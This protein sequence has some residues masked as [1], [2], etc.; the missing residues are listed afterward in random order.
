MSNTSQRPASPSL[1]CQVAIRFNTRPG[2]FDIADQVLAEQ[3]LT[4][5]LP[6]SAD[7]RELFLVS[8]GP[9]SAPPF[10]RPLSHVLVERFC[11]RRT[12]NLTPHEHYVTPVQEHDPDKAL[13]LDLYP[14]VLMINECGPFMLEA[15]QQALIAF[16][17]DTDDKGQTPWQWYSDYLQQQFT[18]AVQDSQRDATLSADALSATQWVQSH[19]APTSQADLDSPTIQVNNLRL[20]FVSNWQLDP[21]LSSALLIER[22]GEQ[23]DPRTTLLYTPTGKLMSFPSRQALLNHA[24]RPW[25]ALPGVSGPD[26][27]LVSPTL[28]YFQSQALGVLC[29]QLHGSQLTAGLEHDLV[30]ATDLSTALDRLTSMFG[31]C[32]PAEA[33]LHERLA[34]HLPAWLKESSPKNLF[35]YSTLLTQIAQGYHDAEYTSWLDGVADAQSFAT[36]K[37]QAHI[38]KEHPE[39]DLDLSTL[40]VVN[41]QTTVAALPVQETIATDITP[42]T[43]TFTL[44][45]LA[46][47]NLGLL[48]PGKVTLHALDGK[49]VPAW[50]DEPYLR[51]LIT[52]V[53]VAQYYPAMLRATLLDDPSQ[54]SRRESLLRRQLH[55]QLPA[56][57]MALNLQGEP[58]DFD[59]IKGI[60]DVFSDASQRS[61]SWQL[62][63]FGLLRSLDASPDHPLNTWL[64]EAQAADPQPCLLYRPL[65]REPLLVFDDRQ[66]LLDAIAAPGALQDDLLDRLPEQ[67]RKVYAHGGFLEPHLFHPL[68]DDWA[69]PLG[70]PAPVTLAL[71]APLA[72]PA[73]AIYQGCIEETIGQFQAHAQTSA[74][75]RWQ[76][77]KSL[78]WLLLNTA[79]PFVAEPLAAPIWTIQLETAF[80]ELVGEHQSQTSGERIAALVE[81][82]VNLALLLLNHAFKRIEALRQA[83]SQRLQTDPALAS[84]PALPTLTVSPPEQVLDFSWANPKRTLAPSQR[85]TLEALCADVSLAQLGKPIPSGLLKGLFLYRDSSWVALNDKVYL[86][87]FDTNQQCPRIVDSKDEFIKG[88]WLRRDEAGRWQLDLGLRLRAGMPLHSRIEQ[89]RIANQ[90]ELETL[91]TQIQEDVTYQK[92]QREYLDKVAKLAHRKAPE[93]ILRNYLAKLEAFTTFWQEHLIRINQFNALKPL[94]DYKVKRAYALSQQLHYAKKIDETLSWL[95]APIREKV[96]D[97]IRLQHGGYELT[98]ADKRS[99][100]QRI[101][102]LLPLLNKLLDNSQSLLDGMEQL[103]RLA[104]RSQPKII[105]Y[106]DAASIDWELVRS[107]LAWRWSRIEACINGLSLLDALDD[108]SEY[109]LQ[110]CGESLDLAF[111]QRQQLL[112]LD[113]SNDDVVSR[114]AASI[115]RHFKTA[116]RQLGNLKSHLNLDTAQPTLTRLQEDIDDAA[117]E[118]QPV[119]DEY[120]AT[121]PSNTVN[122]LRKQVPGLIETQEGDV[123]LGNVRP[124]DDTVVDVPIAPHNASSRSYKLENDRWVALAE[125]PP[126]KPTTV[127]KLKHV[128]KDSQARL[129]TARKELQRLEGSTFSQ[130]LPIEIEELLHHQRDHLRTLREAIEKHLTADNQTDEVSGNRDAAGT[131]KALEDL[132]AQLTRKAVELRTEA[133]LAQ[134]PRMA[135]LRFLIDQGAV[136]VR[137]ENPRKLLARV[138]GRPAD[139]LDDYGIYKGES[140]L[141]VAHFHYRTLEADKRAFVAGHLKPAAQ[142]YAQGAQVSRPDTGQTEEVYR[143]PISLADAQQYF[144]N[145]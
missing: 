66:A 112:A 40:R 11:L 77:W 56:L 135:E 121:L 55:T 36:Q 133:A 33:T 127:R 131:I 69:V 42:H 3:W 14:L 59:V 49:P 87:E 34:S 10:I 38:L 125:Q 5:R 70:T 29:Q 62:R 54:R 92:T 37:L 81:F 39:A 7:P 114:L 85:D 97:M 44:P 98:E 109:W 6:S 110:H 90:Q 72:N 60:G 128:L 78:G 35:R 74:Q 107:P 139:Y 124:D 145:V 130:Y 80:L 1:E 32:S 13:V 23:S 102:T 101:D 16:W 93:G 108:D 94:R 89:L 50:F 2:L 138:K 115:D 63:P 43:E 104:S 26:V 113:Q 76:R 141:W 41:A 136:T 134:K 58:M 25:P 86:V 120:A 71:E 79:L 105:E 88:P 132:D 116:R 21:S 48:R 119:L 117:K 144:F 61:T 143:S 12:L 20:D 65:H 123:L 31:L 64:I 140:L 67:D 4:R 100:G 83:A 129:Q 57:A 99:L 52:Q 96:D 22:A 82:L 15:Y 111:A 51:N 122:Q 24:A 47:S 17:S 8:L 142:R 75:A 30:R 45:Q 106:L 28:P 91:Q 95:H 9:D 137:V 126:A 84:L 46:I 118:L 73:Q 27:H 53:D 68:E 103:Q 18:Q 19:P